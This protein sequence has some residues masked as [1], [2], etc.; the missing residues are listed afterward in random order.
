MYVTTTMDPVG[1]PTRLDALPLGDDVTLVV[2]CG[3]VTVETTG[4]PSEAVPT[5]IVN[6]SGWSLDA[7]VE[8][9]GTVTVMTSG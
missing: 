8:G 3:T 1:V 5:V 6:A 9:S 4:W 2:N 7:D